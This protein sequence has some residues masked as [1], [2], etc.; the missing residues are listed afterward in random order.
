ML[1]PGD[2]FGR[3]RVIA[4]IGR[5]GAGDVYEAHDSKLDRVIALKIARLD[6]A[7]RDAIKGRS[8][9]LLR[10]ARAAAAVVHPNAVAVLDVG[11]V[12]SVPYLVMERLR[13][14][15]LRAY[16]GD[17]SV[18]MSTRLRWL[19]EIADALAAAHA[20]GIVHRD[21]K[22]EN[23]IVTEDSIAKVLDF[24]LARAFAPVD[25]HAETS[26]LR[27]GVDVA[28]PL[29]I[30]TALTEHGMVLGTPEYMAPEQLRGEV[31]DARA[32]QWAWGVMSYEVLS[33]N[34]PWISNGDMVELV[35]RILTADPP[36]MPR[37]IPR[38]VRHSI[39]RCLR[40]DAA[41]RH[42]DIVSA[43]AAILA[44]QARLSWEAFGYTALSVAVAGCL[45][46]SAISHRPKGRWPSG[47][48]E[49]IG[50]SF[51]NNVSGPV[52]PS[53][54]S[55]NVEASA[56]Y[57]EALDALRGGSL[58]PA[59]RLFEKATALDPAFAAAHLRAAMTQ[60]DPD[61]ALRTH[62][63]IAE[64]AR[65]TLGARDRAL[66]YALLPQRNVPVDWE[67]STRR[68]QSLHERSASDAEISFALGWTRV[69]KGDVHGAV[70]AFEE[71]LREDPR[72]AGAWGGILNAYLFMGNIP[73]IRDAAERCV[74]TFPTAQTC[75]QSQL[76]INNIYGHCDE[77]LAIAT[78]LQRIDP[79]EPITYQM[80]ADARFALGDEKGAR[81]AL[82][83]KWA[84]LGESERSFQEPNDRI[85]L[86]VLAGDFAS[87]DAIARDWTIA[88]GKDV[89]EINHYS[90]FILHADLLLESGQRAAAAELAKAYL[91]A[92]PG[93]TT[94]GGFWSTSIYAYG[95][96]YRA[97][98][99]GSAAFERLRAQW[100]Q[101]EEHR[102]S[103][104]T[105]AIRG[106]WW[107]PA[108]ANNV[109]T[110]EDARAGLLALPRFEP[111]QNELN[112]G[113]NREEPLGHIYL[114][115]GR[116][117][118]ALRSLQLAANS[119]GGLEDP[120]YWMS[121][122][123]ELAEALASKGD[124]SG[125]CTAYMHVVKRWGAATPRSVSATMARARMTSL[126]CPL[127]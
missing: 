1:N 69:R 71:A 111:L 27:D 104:N 45:L 9:R 3:F 124:I 81:D 83:A 98:T 101:G 34:R 6:G 46:A 79:L 12:D 42:P 95:V 68:L 92:Q 100:L 23:V 64:Q 65:S 21:L 87:A 19:V 85:N 44:R 49:T 18:P 127:E 56:A 11:E 106:F 97:G 30:A 77:M 2:R 59:Q 62:L 109:V 41:D 57:D 38:N 32:D 112:R 66:L 13:G 26:T 4:F 51:E 37:A 88:L 47:G 108:Y 99:I 72:Y 43:A 123:F 50:A 58:Y 103:G 118:D 94:S 82:L 20:R 91:L 90:A 119:C 114:R 8:A 25:R 80:I 16:V 40:K 113:L 84:R 10:E 73:G 52:E 53:A 33:G 17:P 39:L 15:T 110:A 102:A 96:Q 67:E 107:L 122:V 24:G 22:P 60:A 55:S 7:D 117:E 29:A 105:T 35:A 54:R 31:V 76:K 63:Q 78:R 14:R 115:A 116:L 89:E 74:Q 36:G 126:H 86:A 5:G 93:W 48:A 75:L 70:L 120:T 28:A 61:T 121:S 125:A